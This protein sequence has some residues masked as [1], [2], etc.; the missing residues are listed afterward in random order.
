MSWDNRVQ[1]LFTLREL[2]YQV[3]C[4]MM[5]G[6]PYQKTEDLVADL[7]FIQKLRPHM[8]GIGPF[9]AHKDTPFR[10]QENGTVELT[11]Y[12]LSIIRLMNPYVLLPATTALGDGDGGRTGGGDPSRGQ[13]HHAE[14]LPAVGQG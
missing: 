5:V 10:G 9:L 2:G 4:G 11:L 8:V 13:R 14:P 7:R 1:C 3:G 12:L 6:S